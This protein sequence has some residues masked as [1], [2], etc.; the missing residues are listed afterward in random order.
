MEQREGQNFNLAHA[1]IE[2]VQVKDNLRNNRNVLI[3]K[4]YVD[5]KQT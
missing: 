3:A 5:A 1:Y 4:D 2:Q